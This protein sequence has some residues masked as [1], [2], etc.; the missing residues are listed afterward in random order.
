M[1]RVSPP[2]ISKLAADELM[3]P[4]G[5]LAHPGAWLLLQTTCDYQ[6]LSW[7]IEVHRGT[8][9]NQILVVHGKKMIENVVPTLNWKIKYRKKTALS[10]EILHLHATGLNETNKFTRNQCKNRADE[11]T[12]QRMIIDCLELLHSKSATNAQQ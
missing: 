5:A 2:N 1:S 9:V 7:S 6:K 3:G 4:S 12:D 11:Q 10:P 8:S